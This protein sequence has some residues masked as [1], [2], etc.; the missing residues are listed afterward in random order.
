MRLL[1]LGDLHVGFADNRAALHALPALP[2]DWLIL[3]GDVGE[4]E[5]HLEWAIRLLRPRVARLLW[6]PGNH[7]LWTPRETPG[8]P[9]GVAK[10]ERLVAL[11]R[12]HGVLTPEDAWVLWPGPG[13]AHVIAL[14]FT[15]YDY[16]FRPDN[17]PAERAL[18]WAAQ[19]NTLCADEVLLHPDPY[20]SREAWCQARCDDAE[21]RLAEAARSGARLVLVNHWPLRE[22][23]LRIERIPRFSLWCGTRRT[24]DWHARFGATVVVHGH[25]HVPATDW[26]DGV[27]FEEVSFGYPR[28]RAWRGRAPQTYLRQIL[29]AP[30]TPPAAD[31]SA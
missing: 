19:A 14:L 21:R 16:S 18:L 13:P 26:R 6:V 17:V 7:E 9:R 25:T 11:C 1:A 15:L 23:L 29:P 27:R 3:A 20:P 10:Y 28:E 12:R 4:T 30:E 31:T 5:A 8:A 24:R 22:D 2:E